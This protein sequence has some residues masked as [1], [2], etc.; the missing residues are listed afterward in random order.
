MIPRNLYARL[1]V[2][3][4][5]FRLHPTDA[6]YKALCDDEDEVRWPWAASAEQLAEWERFCG[7]SRDEFDK[8]MTAIWCERVQCPVRVSKLM[9]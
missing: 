7:A 5:D 1:M 6:S 8:A 2:S 9:P 3:L 4:S